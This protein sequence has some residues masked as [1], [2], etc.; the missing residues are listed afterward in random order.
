[1]G[2]RIAKIGHAPPDH[3]AAERRGGDRDSDPGDGGAEEEIVKHDLSWPH[4]MR[5]SRKEKVAEAWAW[6]AGSSPAMT[7]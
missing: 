7:S 3:E 6:M 4:L 1:M 2:G 5:P